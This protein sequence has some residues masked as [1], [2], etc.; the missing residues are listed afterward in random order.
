MISLPISSNM[1]V[2]LLS[3]HCSSSFISVTNM[4]YY[5]Y[6]GQKVLYVHSIN[7]Q[8]TNIM[9]QTIDLSMLH[10]LSYVHLIVS[11]YRHYYNTCPTTTY[12]MNINMGSPNYDQHMMLLHDSWTPS[13]N[14]I[15]SQHQQYSL[16]SAKHMIVY[17]YMD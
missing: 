7:T 12:H 9:S 6:N 13:P 1:A 10:P 17:G 8:V 4:V 11:C 3:L 16:T 14:N 2:P 15:I 5:H